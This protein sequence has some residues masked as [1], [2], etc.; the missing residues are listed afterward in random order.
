MSRD[1]LRANMSVEIPFRFVTDVRGDASLMNVELE[2]P[3]PFTH[4]PVAGR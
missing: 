2:K 1:I 3:L 4:R